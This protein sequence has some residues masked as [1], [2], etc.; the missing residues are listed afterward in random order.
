MLIPKKVKHRKWQTQRRNPKRSLPESRGTSLAFG[1]YGLK[2]ITS[3]RVKSNQLEASRK[4]MSRFIKKTGKIW[5]RVFTDRPFTQK[6]PEVKLGKGKGDL[7]GY[8]FWVKPGRILFE[9][10]GVDDATAVS[11][12]MRAGDKLPVKTIVVKRH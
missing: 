9:I 1:S 2:A 5:I 8:C 7:A 11:S 6:P 10:D 4:A 3:G 12:L